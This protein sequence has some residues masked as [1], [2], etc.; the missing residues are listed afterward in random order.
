[1]IMD[2]A[3]MGTLEKRPSDCDGDWYTVLTYAILLAKRLANLHEMGIEH[4]DLHPGNVV[5]HISYGV[6][7]IDVGLSQAVENTYSGNGVYGRPAY[8]PPESFR[9]E[10]YTQKSDIYCLGTLIWQLVVGVPPQGVAPFDSNDLG[11]LR[12][13]LIPGAPESFNNIISS[14]WHFHQEQRP[15]AFEIYNQLLECAADLAGVLSTSN[16]RDEYHILGALSIRPVPF[17]SE[18]QSYIINRR[19]NQ[20]NIDQSIDNSFQFVESTSS[21]SFSGSKY[22]T[23]KELV[24]ISKEYS[25]I[26]YINSPNLGK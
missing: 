1:M 24:Q 23:Q 2:F 13:E 17:S 6:F 14:C 4:R 26:N 21:I 9:Q 10:Q 19:I 20:Q 16:L 7:L 3:D 25:R 18:T 8:F 12:E 5:F 11:K 15:S 22:F